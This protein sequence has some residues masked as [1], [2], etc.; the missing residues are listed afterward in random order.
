MASRGQKT[1]SVAGFG[2]VGGATCV[3][4]SQARGAAQAFDNAQASDAAHASGAALLPSVAASLL[5]DSAVLRS[6][7]CFAGGLDSEN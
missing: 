4:A 3:G 1:P 2:G 5:E 7:V 6:C